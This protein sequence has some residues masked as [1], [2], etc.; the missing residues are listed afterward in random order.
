MR[1][2]QL[3]ELEAQCHR[4]IGTLYCGILTRYNRWYSH[5]R[6]RILFPKT[7]EKHLEKYI[8]QLLDVYKMSSDYPF[9]RNKILTKADEYCVELMRLRSSYGSSYGR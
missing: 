7:K 2:T 8:G 1:I 9:W 4:E 3:E 6:D 5:D